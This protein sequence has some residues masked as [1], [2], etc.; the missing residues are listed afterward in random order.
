MKNA[1][2]RKN[3]CKICGR[4]STKEFCEF[5][6]EALR[7]L[8]EHFQIWKERKCIGWEDYLIEILKNERTGSWI[9]EVAEHLIRE[10]R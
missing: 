1:P 9:K 5:H 2:L 7:R 10:S 3:I 8:K 6:E 4:V